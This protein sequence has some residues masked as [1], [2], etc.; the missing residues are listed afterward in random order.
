MVTYAYSLSPSGPA[1]SIQQVINNIEAEL[2]TNP[3]IDRDIE[4][5]LDKGNYAGFTI[6][7][8]ALFPLMNTPYR[9]IIKSS[10][11]HF[12]IIDFNYSPETQIVGIDVGSGNPNVT[13]KGLRVQYFAIGI[14]VGLNSHYPIVRNCIANNNRNVGIMLEQAT[15]SQAIQNVVINGDYGIVSRLCKSST[16]IHNTIFQNGAISTEVGKSKACVWAELA[17]DYGNGLADTGVLHLIGNVAWNTSG[18]CLTLFSANVDLP[19]AIVS[20]Y[21]DWVVGDP[22]DFIAIEDNAFFFGPEAEPRQ[23]F[24][25]L[26]DWK[27]L[28]YDANSISQDPK[29]IAPV[30]LRS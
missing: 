8:G 14:R 16:I 29:F 19:G 18:R 15:E 21:N 2:S 3:T 1:S 17:N 13:I 10:G 30:K 9:L 22:D 25:S 26:M 4:V 6:P 7:T 24:T 27:Q 11:N 28:G 23:V 20:N 12:P 5:L